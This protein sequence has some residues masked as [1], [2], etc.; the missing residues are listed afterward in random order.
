MEKILVD[1]TE[2]LDK[3]WVELIGNALEIGI[4]SEQIREFLHNFPNS[5][6]KNL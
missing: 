4:S 1:L 6:H 3:E 2:N 5:P